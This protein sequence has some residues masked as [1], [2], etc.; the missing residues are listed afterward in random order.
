MPTINIVEINCIRLFAGE[1]TDAYS[2][3]HKESEGRL[4]DAAMRLR[5]YLQ[6]S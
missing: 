3:I 4:V 6:M 2:S 1:D 5:G